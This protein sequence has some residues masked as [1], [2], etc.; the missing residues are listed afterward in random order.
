[1]G[2]VEETQLS[3]AK[4][5]NERKARQHFRFKDK[6]IYYIYQDKSNNTNRVNNFRMSEMHDKTTT[7]A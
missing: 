1:M 4:S 5:H 3:S 7:N 6:K 2:G